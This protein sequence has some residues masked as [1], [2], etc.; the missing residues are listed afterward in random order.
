[1]TILILNPNSTRAMTEGVEH[2]IRPLGYEVQCA[3]Y[4]YS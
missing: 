2:A 1:M 3:R 4:R